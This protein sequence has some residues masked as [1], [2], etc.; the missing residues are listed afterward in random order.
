MAR[1]VLA[2]A[3]LSGFGGLGAA[4]AYE[5]AR[6]EEELKNVDP[7]IRPVTNLPQCLMQVFVTGGRAAGLRTGLF[8][9]LTPDALLRAAQE[10]TGLEDLGEYSEEIRRSLE[11]YVDCV[12][13]DVRHSGLGMFLRQQLITSNL[14][15]LLLLVQHVKDHPEVLDVAIREPV[16]ITGLPRT[17]TTFL[18]T[19]LSLDP[20]FRSPMM[21]ELL[22]GP[23]P[24]PQENDP[25]AANL[26]KE[27]DISMKY[28]YN[29]LSSSHALNAEQPEECVIWHGMAF[30]SLTLGIDSQSYRKWESSLPSR[31]APLHLAK[32]A[33][34]TLQRDDGK[35]WLLKSPGYVFYMDEFAQIFPDAKFI[36]THREPSRAIASWCSLMAKISGPYSFVPALDGPSWVEYW[37]RGMQRCQADREKFKQRGV[38]VVDVTFRELNE[39][40]L[41]VVKNI[42]STFG[43]DLSPEV[44]QVMKSYIT[45]DA[46]RR[47]QRNPHKPELEWFGLTTG[48]VDAA[49]PYW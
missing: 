32:L 25:R 45:E 46:I 13:K 16:V 15:N 4:V 44:E 29:D 42:Y 12:N 17:G 24:V 30:Q 37:A 41:G 47:K 10:E 11:K 21:W 3:G 27:M 33:Y 49:F 6:L 1:R 31:P 18:H 36:M 20:R 43:W 26:A 39:N 9:D 34:Q 7:S 40:P 19:L 23:V 8:A 14:K 38:P 5:R 22:R 2:Y 35:T 28:L 48:A